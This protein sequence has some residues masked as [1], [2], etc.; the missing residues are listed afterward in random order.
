MFSSKSIK[1]LTLK[2]RS[3]VHSRLFWAVWGRSPA[4]FFCL[5]MSYCV[6]ILSLWRTVDFCIMWT[7]HPCWSQLTVKISLYFWALDSSHW[8]ICPHI[9]TTLSY[10]WACGEHWSQEMRIL[11]LFS[12]S[13]DSGIPWDSVWISGHIFMF[14]QEKKADEI[15]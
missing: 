5:W 7:W 2:F 15:L 6:G 11:W 4:S 10:H 8:F 12:S 14:L 9:T 13:F 1:V 3:L